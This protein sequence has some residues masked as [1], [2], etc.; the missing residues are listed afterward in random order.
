MTSEYKLREARFFLEQIDLH[1]TDLEKCDYCVS[2]FLHATHDIIDHTFEEYALDPF[3]IKVESY[4]RNKIADFINIAQQQKNQDALGFIEIYLRELHKIYTQAITASLLFIRNVNT[5]KETSLS[6]LAIWSELPDGGKRF[7]DR[8]FLSL[9]NLAT[10]R[11]ENEFKG[12]VISQTMKLQG[13]GK[14]LALYLPVISDAEFAILFGNVSAILTETDAK[15]VCKAHLGLLENFV[16][17]IRAK[18]RRW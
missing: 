16:G 15:D 13:Y 12:Y 9:V 1:Y 7:E 18:Y 10:P 3:K 8:Y 4:R 14:I 2:A 11:F 5:H 6:P 17:A